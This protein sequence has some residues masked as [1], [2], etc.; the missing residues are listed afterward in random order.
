MKSATSAYVFAAVLSLAGVSVPA[1]VVVPAHAAGSRLGR[2]AVAGAHGPAQA[3][4]RI[5]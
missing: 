5:S 1:A 4:D 2:G 3:G